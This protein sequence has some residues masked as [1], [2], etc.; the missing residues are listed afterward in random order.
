VVEPA[1]GRHAASHWL[2]C[3]SASASRR[4]PE[5]PGDSL[6]HSDGRP[7]GSVGALPAYESFGA[8]GSHRPPPPCSSARARRGGRR[9]SSGD[10]RRSSAAAVS[11]GVVSL[12]EQAAT[13][14]SHGPGSNGG[15][16]APRPAVQVSLPLAWPIPPVPGPRAATRTAGVQSSR[17]SRNPS[18]PILL[19]GQRRSP[20][21]GYSRTRP[22]PRKQAHP[23]L[24]ATPRPCRDAEDAEPNAPQTAAVV[25]R[26]ARSADCSYPCEAAV[27]P[28]AP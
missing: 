25:E 16:R 21:R 19:R 18:A 13:A 20:R 11:I 24:P 22:A 6:R 15:E 5:A 7:A 2:S 4:H 27:E 12:R 1:P 23:A 28:L 8:F 17:A 10:I 3:G 9:A 14:L 26:Q